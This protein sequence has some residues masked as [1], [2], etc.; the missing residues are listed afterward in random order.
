MNDAVAARIEATFGAP[1][2]AMRRVH[3]SWS[4]VWAVD[5]A[6][7]RRIA[8]KVGDAPRLEARM[9]TLLREQGGLPT[10][11]IYHVD[12]EMML[13]AWVPGDAPST[14]AAQTHAADLLVAAHAVTA[15]THGLDFDTV[16][17]PL[18]QRNPPTRDWI[19]FFRDHRL[20][21]TA[22]AAHEEGRIAA[23]DLARF[24]RLGDR[25]P[26]L[27]EE[28]ARPS[29]LHGDLWSG[30]ILADERRILA[31]IDPAVYYGHFEIELAF[32]ALFSSFGDAFF[33]RY[34]E[35]SGLDAAW[36]EG[37]FGLRRDIYN[38]YPLLIHARLFGGGYGDQAAGIAARHVG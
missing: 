23:A 9:L 17:G 29:L 12:S 13:T 27:L 2:A 34:A 6:D 15:P 31:V 37:F 4:A 35:R 32:G 28:P 24:E 7:G 22:R 26:D 16:I 18:K 5:L 36:R 30:N 10:P 8:A 14:D 11:E 33:G 19:A 20:L 21:R 38:I 3:Q 1:P 25:L